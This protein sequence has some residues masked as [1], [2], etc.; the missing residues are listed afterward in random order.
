[1][2]SRRGFQNLP[3]P[4]IGQSRMN[5]LV[6]WKVVLNPYLRSQWLRLVVLAS[7][8]FMVR[9][10]TLQGQ[11]IWDDQLLIHDNPF[12]KSPLLIPETFRHFLFPDGFSGHYRPVQNVS[13]FFDYWLWNTNLY[14]FHLT[15]IL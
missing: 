2:S 4:Q 13:F 10:P 5:R 8:G 9:S 1:M 7:V 15:N 3:P 14:G 12:I 11:P 6:R